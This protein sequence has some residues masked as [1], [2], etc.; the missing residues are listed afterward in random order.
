MKNFLIFTF[1]FF[2]LVFSLTGCMTFDSSTKEDEA[3]QMRSSLSEQLIQVKQ[4]INTLKGQVDELQYK[5]DKISQSQSQ[6][7]NEINSTLKNSKTESQSSI[8]NIEKKISSIEAKIQA[9]EKKQSQDKTELQSKTDI[10]VEEVSKENK[11]LRKE[12]E[13][14]KKTPLQTTSKASKNT[15]KQTAQDGY[16]T[17]SA[18]DT[19]V[20]IAQMYGIPLK[21]LMEANNISDPNSINIGQKLIVPE[22]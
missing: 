19:L 15:Q 5:I 21:S 6:Q 11:E 14:I 20:K 10:I 18:G 13:S 1:L 8:S 2:T 22:N 12:I 17:V 4:D 3:S 9:L 16:Y 7:S